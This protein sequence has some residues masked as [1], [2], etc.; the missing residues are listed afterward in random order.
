MR[1]SPI[2]INNYN[3]KALIKVQETKIPHAKNDYSW[4]TNAPIQR[5][6]ILCDDR[7][8]FNRQT[9]S[10]L[11]DDIDWNLYGE[12][13]KKNFN[14]PKVNT[15]IYGCANGSEAYSMSLLLQGIFGE[16]AERFF[17][18]IASDIRENTIFF[19]NEDKKDGVRLLYSE[20]KKICKLSYF[21][22]NICLDIEKLNKFV[23][24]DTES[25]FLYTPFV[26]TKDVSDKVIFKQV[27]ILEDIDSID[28]EN[29]SIVMCRNMW[30]YIESGQYEDYT[31]K[32][33]EKL[34]KGSIV[35]L[36]HYDFMGEMYKK[37]SSLFRIENSNCFPVVLEN[38]GF[39]KASTKIGKKFG[40]TDLIFEKK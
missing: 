3:F 23:Q 34:A 9:T 10:L 36:G 17:P 14:Q 7:S 29:P 2:Q 6:Q 27:N 35:V 37:D 16:D 15:Y 5:G 26:L 30:P 20:Y 22:K 1:I 24:E 21:R 12:Y 25:N 33:Y 19:N 11:R 39:E 32:L 40:R 18:I 31:S 8:I 28:S 4:Y 13:I 38:A